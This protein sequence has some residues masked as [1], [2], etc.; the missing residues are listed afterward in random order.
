MISFD[1]SKLIK[2]HYDVTEFKTALMHRYLVCV[3]HLRS[4]KLL[5]SALVEQVATSVAST[6]YRDSKMIQELLN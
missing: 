4:S 6:S 5:V 2:R 1:G 3:H